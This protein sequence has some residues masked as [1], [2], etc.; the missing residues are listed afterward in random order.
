V[1]IVCAINNQ[2]QYYDR[3]GEL[4]VAA[5]IGT[6]TDSMG[7]SFKTDAIYKL[8]TDS[9]HRANITRAAIG[10]ID[11]KGAQRIVDAMMSLP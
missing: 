1:G 2:K 11:F 5:Q 3:L 7:W 6:R 9:E 8:L 10:L 4:G